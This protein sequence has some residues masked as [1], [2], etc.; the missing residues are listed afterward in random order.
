MAGRNNFSKDCLCPPWS[1]STPPVI[2]LVVLLVGSWGFGEKY[3]HIIA[4][5]DWIE[6][7]D[8][9]V[10]SSRN[11]KVVALPQVKSKSLC[12]T[13]LHG[14]PS[15]CPGS[16]LLVGTSVGTV[17][18][19][20]SATRADRGRCCPIRE[21]YSTVQYF[22]CSWRAGGAGTFGRACWTVQ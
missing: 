15:R 7:R 6:R 17:L 4:G 13:G 1:C 3:L 21:L 12:A 18:E 9:R 11:A 22:T 8:K 19:Q 20:A 14:M 16:H 2:T 5:P 10:P